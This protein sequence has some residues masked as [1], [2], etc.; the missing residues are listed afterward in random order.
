MSLVPRTPV[1]AVGRRSGVV[2]RADVRRD[3][4][5]F[6]D[7]D[8]FWA[9]DSD[10]NDDSSG[11]PGRGNFEFSDSREEE[12]DAGSSQ[13]RYHRNIVSGLPPPTVRKKRPSPEPEPV[14]VK[15]LHNTLLSPSAHAPREDEPSEVNISFGNMSSPAST[16]KNRRSSS[17]MD[18]TNVDVVTPVQS[19]AP[20]PRPQA[21][22][23]PSRRDASLSDTSVFSVPRRQPPPLEPLPVVRSQDDDDEKA[24]DAFEGRR[25]SAPSR[26][27]DA[28][29]DF[30]APA[31]EASDPFENDMT[32][33]AQAEEH[34][35]TSPADMSGVQMQLFASPPTSPARPKTPPPTKKKAKRPPP[36][37]NDADLLDNASLVQVAAA[38]PAAVKPVKPKT[39]G[40]PRKKKAEEAATDTSMTTDT[41]APRRQDA[42]DDEADSDHN[43]PR[44]SKRRRIQPLAWYKCERP[45]YERRDNGL[46]LILPTISH[47]ERAGTTSPVKNAGA[48][49]KRGPRHAAF[50]AANLPAEYTYRT[51]DSGELWDE[52]AATAKT[53]KM[54]GRYGT[55]DTFALPATDGHPPGFA[56]QT[57]NV[58]GNA[59]VPTWISGRVLLP[60]Q[61][62][63]APESVGACT[64]VF[65]VVAC[66]PN[67]LEV[68]FG[69]PSDS[70]F[71]D[72]TA[73]RYTLGPG[74]EFYV[75]ANNAY[76]LRNH[77]PTV[78]AELRFMILKPKP[79]DKAK[80][81]T[82]GKKAKKAK[83]AKK[84]E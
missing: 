13:V 20:S 5:G 1:Q 57:F 53:V 34:K 33:I 69:H 41:E 80:K 26:T 25:E 15:G 63:K 83:K 35:L 76:F 21:A 60:P 47:I 44:R 4:H 71:Q 62:L 31:F 68:S 39:K 78:E 22:N 50:P 18:L 79:G 74:D 48:P 36:A 9:E 54:I 66:Q 8:D 23:P 24:D 84:G 6:E 27:S 42:T 77:S 52:A 61:A 49:R 51:T 73:Q 64:Q 29:F 59:S 81:A 19:P 67:A 55:S 16:V 43:G 38:K 2:V 37:T 3:S 7:I 70:V 11:E 65:V 32:P 10:G 12:D 45:V 30:A 40:R 17:S 46:G 56:G 82:D 58:V 75:P 14:A 72:T 28:D